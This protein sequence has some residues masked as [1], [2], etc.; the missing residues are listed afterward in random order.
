[1]AARD[2]ETGR[3]GT[4]R[5]TFQ[6]PNLNRE[7]KTVPISTVVLGSQL[8]PLNGGAQ[9]GVRPDPLVY[10]GL[11]LLPSVT[12]EFS[13]SRDMYVFL[14]AYQRDAT[15]TQPLIATVALYRDGVKAFETVPLQVTEGL[16]PRSKAVPVRL[17][18]PLGGLAP[19]VY[20]CEVSVVDTLGQKVTFWRTPVIL[21]P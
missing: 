10:D 15:T 19:G 8:V 4:F 16:E 12:R 13:T 21:V 14:Q 17:T 6:V 18:V 3:I 7:E 1:L 20:D 9:N 2:A 11:K 5:T